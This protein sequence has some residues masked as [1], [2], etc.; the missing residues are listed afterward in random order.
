MLY[1]SPELTLAY[2]TVVPLTLI[3]SVISRSRVRSSLRDICTAVAKL[4]LFLQEILVGITEVQLFNYEQRIRQDLDAIKEE[5]SQAKCQPV[6][7]RGVFHSGQMECLNMLG[8]PL[9][10]ALGGQ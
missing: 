10:V 1:S 4:A 9:L 2:L 7:V 8:F 6:R 5:H 3:V